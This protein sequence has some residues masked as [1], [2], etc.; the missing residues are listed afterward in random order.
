MK[1]IA[2][3]LHIQITQSEFYNLRNYKITIRIG[4]EEIRSIR[5]LY[6]NF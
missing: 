2:I 4:S 6:I 3:F 1:Q 5:R